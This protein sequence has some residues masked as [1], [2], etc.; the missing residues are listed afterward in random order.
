MT[1]STAQTPG[2]VTAIAD[3]ASLLDQRPTKGGIVYDLLYV[4]LRAIISCVFIVC[5][6]HNDGVI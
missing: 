5:D 6:D 4:I 1:T 2:V 3:E